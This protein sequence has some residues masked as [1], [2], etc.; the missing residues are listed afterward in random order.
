MANLS[1]TVFEKDGM[2]YIHSDVP[3]NID[4]SVMETL[5]NLGIK[6]MAPPVM[7]QEITKPELHKFDH[8][9]SITKQKYRVIC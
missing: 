6:V 1:V 2:I 3:V 4:R 9:D 7:F 5:I 8:N